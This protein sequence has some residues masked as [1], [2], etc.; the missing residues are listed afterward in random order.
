MVHSKSLNKPLSVLDNPSHQLHSTQN[1][2]CSFSHGLIQ[3]CWNKGRFWKSFF[4]FSIK[5]YNSFPFCDRWTQLS[6]HKLSHTFLYLSLLLTFFSTYYWFALLFERNLF[7]TIIYSKAF[8]ISMWYF[9]NVIII[10]SFLSF[11]THKVFRKL[12]LWL[13]HWG[14][15]SLRFELNW[16]Y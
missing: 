10:P 7:S 15:R 5:L 6:E 8:T 12:D 16:D 13:C 2:Q 9:H 1:Q 14:S 4:V 11:F 3:P